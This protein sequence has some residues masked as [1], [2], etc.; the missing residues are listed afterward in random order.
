MPLDAKTTTLPIVGVGLRHPHYSNAL[1]SKAPVDFV[2]I[3]SENFFAGGGAI[4]AVLDEIITKYLV[5]LHS[6]G[7]GSA[8]EASSTYYKKLIALSYKVQP[9]LISDHASF[10]WSRLGDQRIHLGD[11]LPISFN[12]QSLM[13]LCHHVDRAQ[14]R[15]GRQILIENLSAYVDMDDNSMSETEFLTELSN[16]TGC[17]L[18]VDLNNIIVS[19]TNKKEPDILAY[20]QR[21][22]KQLPVNKVGEFHLAGFT[23]PE[24]GDYAVDDHS[25]AVSEECWALY[26]F[27]LQ[28]FGAIPTLIEWDNNLP[29]WEVLLK[30]VELARGIGKN[31]FKTS[32]SAHV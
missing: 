32:Q 31:T 15:L 18:L 10:S 5:S 11:L 20:A 30:Q 29:S 13:V 21:W 22:L 7:L 27:A 6:T 12:E 25:Q 16:T 28:H 9:I 1:S 24:V 23:P 8:E 3:H 2:E 14:Q 4:A 17:G 19:A 26:A